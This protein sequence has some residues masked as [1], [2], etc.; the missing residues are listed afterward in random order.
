MGLLACPPSYNKCCEEVSAVQAVGLASESSQYWA[1]GRARLV[2]S[3]Q[4]VAFH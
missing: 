3:G 1:I 4:V 2:C